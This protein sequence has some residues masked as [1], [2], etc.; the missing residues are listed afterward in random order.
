M[1]ASGSPPKRSPLSYPA[2]RLLWLSSIVT[3]VGSFVQN[4]GEAWL[5]MDL[6][7]SFTGNLG[8]V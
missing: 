8:S 4:V 5:M 2:F 7:R 1:N 6:P 3:F